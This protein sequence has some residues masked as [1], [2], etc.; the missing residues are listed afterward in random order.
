MAFSVEPGIY[1][2]GEYGA[3]IEDIVVCGPDGPI[4]L[5]EAPRD[6]VRRR[7]LRR[8]RP[9]RPAFGEAACGIIGSTGRARCDPLQPSSTDDQHTPAPDR[10]R[11]HRRDSDVPR[12]R[13][14]SRRHHGRPHHHAPGGL[15]EPAS[16]RRRE[17]R[18]LDAPA[19]MPAGDTPRTARHRR[20]ARQARPPS[21]PTTGRRPR[22]SR[23]T[24]P[25]R[26]RSRSPPG[27][28][29]QATPIGPRDDRPP[30]QPRRSPA[31]RRH[32]RRRVRRRLPR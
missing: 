9:L 13:P 17:P 21:L 2:V 26:R 6:A 20:R 5:N 32:R 24:S 18:P 16:D 12:T 7:R 22:R 19:P 15:D 3:R 27:R 23:D 31:P 14:M 1:L 10:R 28:T 4:A 29:P 30:A 11:Q 8:P 25:R